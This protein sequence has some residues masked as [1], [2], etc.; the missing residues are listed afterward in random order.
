MANYL[1]GYDLDK[2]DQNY[3]ELFKAIEAIGG[4]YW[5]CLDSTWIVKSNLTAIQLCNSLS[6]HIGSSD[7]LLVAA[8]SKDAA[9]IGFDKECSD[10]LKTNL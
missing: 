1:I 10:W 6:K 7:K 5:H 2:P 9:W 3:K 8:L 4:S